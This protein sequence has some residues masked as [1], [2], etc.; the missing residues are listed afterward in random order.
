MG[1]LDTHGHKGWWPMLVH[2]RKRTDGVMVGREGFV[3]MRN[4]TICEP[5][6]GWNTKDLPY[7]TGETSSLQHQSDSFRENFDLIDWSGGKVEAAPDVQPAI[8]GRRKFVD[9]Y[10]TIRWER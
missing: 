3:D 1:R 5:E 8:E 2:S 6:D 4:G 10:D 9:N 7:A